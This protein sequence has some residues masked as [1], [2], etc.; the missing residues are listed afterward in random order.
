V[1]A[2][3]PTAALALVVLFQPPQRQCALCA[4]ETGGAEDQDFVT[5]SAIPMNISNFRHPDGSRD[6]D[7]PHVYWL[8]A[9]VPAFT[10]MMKTGMTKY[11]M[12]TGMTETVGP[13]GMTDI[14]MAEFSNPPPGFD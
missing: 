13:A 6:P 7:F 12:F 5:F 10:G 9:W 14:E 8:K 4:A 2:I 3:K 11:E 1:R